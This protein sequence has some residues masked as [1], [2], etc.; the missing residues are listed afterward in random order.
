MRDSKGY[1]VRWQ[2]ALTRE[3]AERWFGTAEGA[4]EYLRSV[5]A[6]VDPNAYAVASTSAEAQPPEH[7][8]VPSH[9]A[10]AREYAAQQWQDGQGSARTLAE[11]G[12]DA[13]EQQAER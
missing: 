1:M 7:D 9:E 13:T 3:W 8:Q 6:S 10:E 4:E 2:S 11:R 12:L 5:K